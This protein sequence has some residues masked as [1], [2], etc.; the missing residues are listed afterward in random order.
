[1]YFATPFQPIL[2]ATVSF[3][4]FGMGVAV[5]DFFESAAV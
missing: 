3:W 2:A 1:M 5:F 4:A